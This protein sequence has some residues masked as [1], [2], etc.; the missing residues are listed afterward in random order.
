MRDYDENANTCKN[1]RKACVRHQEFGIEKIITHSVNYIALIRL[2]RPIQ[3]GP[4]MKPICLPFGGNHIP[5]PLLNSNLVVT[6][7][8]GDA[9]V[10]LSEISS[11][12]TS[13]PASLCT[14]EYNR[15]SCGAQG[16]LMN[17]FENRRMVLE[18]INSNHSTRCF[19]N[20][21]SVFTHIR[22]YGDWLSQNMKM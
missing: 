21:Y 19:T 8:N 10:T 6:K 4:K 20:R 5:E 17:Q 9:D 22:S 14:V 2:N 12:R 16:L 7:R 15:Y 18:G 13:T 11:C 3:F 1:R